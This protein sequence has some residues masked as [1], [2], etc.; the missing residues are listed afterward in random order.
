MLELRYG[1]DDERPRTL[2]EVGARVQLTRE[3]IRQIETSRSRSSNLPEAQKLRDD[4]EIPSSDE[5]R[6]L[7]HRT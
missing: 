6:P 4:V 7:G 5:L 1:L 2:D 3:R